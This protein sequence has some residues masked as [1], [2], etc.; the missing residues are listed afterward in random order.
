V[1]LYVVVRS[2]QSFRQSLEAP[3]T[4][5]L[6]RTQIEMQAHRQAHVKVD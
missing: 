5:D 4:D 3:A 2:Y 1:T 6:E